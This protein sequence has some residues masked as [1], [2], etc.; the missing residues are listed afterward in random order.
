MECGM[1]AGW[2]RHPLPRQW[3]RCFSSPLGKS[4]QPFVCPTPLH[5]HG[6]TLHPPLLSQKLY[7]GFILLS[8]YALGY[9]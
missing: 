4:S 2:T 7:R 1:G 5:S 6:H 3:D 9:I 8:Q